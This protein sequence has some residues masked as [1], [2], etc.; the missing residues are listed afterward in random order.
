MAERWPEEAAIL[1]FP[2]DLS[3][4]PV[5]SDGEA[6]PFAFVGSAGDA[7]V[8]T[9]ALGEGGLVGAV[10][11]AVGGIRVVGVSA[12]ASAGCPGSDGRRLAER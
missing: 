3:V 12:R 8:R 7:G 10:H 5:L 6:Q 4:H 9:P 2:S 11:R 1:R